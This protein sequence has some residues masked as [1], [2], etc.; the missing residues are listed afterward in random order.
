LIIPSEVEIFEK[1]VLAWPHL[2]GVAT[3]RMIEDVL[4]NFI[5]FIPLGFLLIATLSRIETVGDRTGLLVAV[6][7]AFSFSLCIEVAQ[8]W[9]PTRDSSM[10]DLLLNTFGGGAGVMLFR[11]SRVSRVDRVG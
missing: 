5:G 7:I 1:D 4:I 10:L 8:V 3:P 11:I 9:I 6:L 2:G